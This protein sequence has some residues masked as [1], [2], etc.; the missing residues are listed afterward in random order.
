MP[1]TEKIERVAELKERI[2]SSQA[3]FL[4]DFRGLTV[5]ESG[6][7]RRSLSSAGAQLA[8]VKNTLMK[9]AAA[10]AGAGELEGLL[11]GPTAVAFVQEDAIA[12]AKSLVDAARRFR[13]LVLKGGFLEGRVLSPEEAQS[14][15]TIESREV[16]L[17][18][19]A[20][21]A[22]AEMS[23]AAFMFNALQ[24]RFLALLE[25]FRE[26]LPG[27]G[28]ADDGA[29]EPSADE[30]PAEAPAEERPAEEPPAAEDVSADEAPAADE[31][32]P[33][34][35]P[36]AEA[37]PGPSEEATEATDG[38]V[39]DAAAAEASP[40]ATAGAA[41]ATQPASETDDEA[42]NDEEGA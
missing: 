35:V 41:E 23:R 26:K 8:V 15:A 12:A 22:K 4:A 42:T 30:T 28:G 5:A 37:E 31:G 10:D 20:G 25:A 11:E 27:E 38:D 1:K 36:A 24:S 16:L 40:D 39:S 19:M 17:A 33:E 34:E 18:K 3:L 2:Q 13:T 6:E 14:L 21:L 9:I 29:A 7:L 32:A